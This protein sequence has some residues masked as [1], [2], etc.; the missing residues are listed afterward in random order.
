MT[1]AHRPLVAVDIGNTTVSLGCYEG[2]DL[3][4]TA[5]IPAADAADL[6]N[7]W[8]DGFPST[9]DLADVV[10]VG[11]SVNPA[12]RARVETALAEGGARLLLV[13]RDLAVTMEVRLREP[14][15]IGPDRL[16]NA[17][18][19]YGRIRGALVIVDFGT[20]VT[21]DCVSADGAYLGGSIAPGVRLGIAALHEHTALLPRID[22]PDNPPPLGTDTVTAMQSGVFWGTVG[23]VRELLHRERPCFGRDAVVLATGGDAALFAPHIP[24]IS[25]VAPH[26]TL[27]GLR[28]IYLDADP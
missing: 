15:K 9:A 28:R 19:A 2:D 7:R 18:E 20:A 1:A 13:P 27:A 10:C 14:A 6:L 4:A 8:P 5:R 25:R 11:C 3:T 21:L 16:V 23:A 24:E 17:Y 12:V 26:L 22:L